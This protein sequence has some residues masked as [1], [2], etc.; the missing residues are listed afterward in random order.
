MITFFKDVL[1]MNCMA[2]LIS[3]L[4]KLCFYHS[5]GFFTFFL[6][7]KSLRTTGNFQGR[8]FIDHER[9]G[10]EMNFADS[11]CS[12]EK[13]NGISIT[14]YYCKFV[15]MSISRNIIMI[16]SRSILSYCTVLHS[17]LL[18]INY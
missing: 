17:V 12:I 9:T 4:D 5:L 10:I 2:S 11:P 16:S 7:L 3:L 6:A 13:K 18:K 15:R 1:R 8:E 14:E